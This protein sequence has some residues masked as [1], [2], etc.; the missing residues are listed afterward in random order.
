MAENRKFKYRH[1]LGVLQD[2]STEELNQDV[3][4]LDYLG[5]FLPVDCIARYDGVGHAL[6]EGHWFLSERYP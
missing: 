1:L 2:M 5:Q 6:D 3:T 4:I